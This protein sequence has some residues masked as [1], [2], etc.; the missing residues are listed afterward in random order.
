MDIE[1]CLTVRKNFEFT[2]FER[3]A[4]KTLVNVFLYVCH[5]AIHNE[6]QCI[7]RQKYKKIYM[8]IS[9]LEKF[10]VEK[11]KSRTDCLPASL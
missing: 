11:A 4:D 1:H 3:T 9:F 8:M 10:W 6:K 2:R 7:T 5:T